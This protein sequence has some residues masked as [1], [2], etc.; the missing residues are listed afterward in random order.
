MLH[1]IFGRSGSGKSSFVLNKANESASDGAKVVLIVP[2]QFTFETER[3]LVQNFGPQSCLY[4]EA[5]SFSRLVHRIMSLYGGL[6]CRYIDDCG[7]YILMRL[8]LKQV[9]DML[10]VYSRQAG[11][12]SFAKAMVD[13]VGEYKVCGIDADT[14]ETAAR[15]SGGGLLRQKLEDISLIMSV[16]NALLE[17]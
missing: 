13:A 15:K 6:A 3:A 7:R 14:L 10:K 1:L 11:G 5:L 16:Y 4:I 12:A 17:N 8:A 9:C 2:E